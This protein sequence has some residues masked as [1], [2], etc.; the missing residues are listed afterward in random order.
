MLHVA[1]C[2][3]HVACCMLHVGVKVFI[4]FLLGSLNNPIIHDSPPKLQKILC[5]ARRIHSSARRIHS[6]ARRIHSC[7][8]RIHSCSRRIHSCSRRIQCCSRRIQCCSRRIHSCSRRIQCCSRRIL[9]Y[10]RREQRCLRH[11]QRGARG[12]YRRIRQIVA[13]DT[14]RFLPTQ[15]WSAWGRGNCGR[16]RQIVAHDTVRF[17][18]SQEWS[19]W[20]RGIVGDF[21]HCAGDN[22][23]DSAIRRRQ[24]TTIP[25]YAHTLPSPGRPFLRRQESHNC[26]P[27]T[28]AS[29]RRRCR[30]MAMRFLPTQEWSS[31]ER[32]NRGRIRRIVWATIAK[33]AASRSN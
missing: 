17:L 33:N 4:R 10:L 23:A 9:R 6:S 29:L 24:R 2:M 15:E 11:E 13:H 18:P 30:P 8:R 21:W 20:G 27:P 28:A 5:L 31:G 26:V 16:I 19:A 22:L 1:C 7:S 32:E 14:V 3:L 12:I 25:K